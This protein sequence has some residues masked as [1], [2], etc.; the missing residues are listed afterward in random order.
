M[1]AEDNSQLDHLPTLTEDA[2]SALDTDQLKK[3][4]NILE[5]ERNKLKSVANIH[6]YI[7]YMKKDGVYKA[8]LVEVEEIT[9]VRQAM[10][11]ELECLKAQRLS[12]FMQVLHCANSLLTV[13]CIS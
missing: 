2:L 6:A 4:I 8:R 7:E 13:L 3:E 9:K 12:A 5:A 1:P 11:Q 10:L